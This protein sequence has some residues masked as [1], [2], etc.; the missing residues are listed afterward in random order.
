MMLK[1]VTHFFLFSL[2]QLISVTLKAVFLPDI[3]LESITIWNDVT[4]MMQ[5]YSVLVYVVFFIW[6]KFRDLEQEL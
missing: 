6:V 5:W 4:Q 2:I 3:L 1:E